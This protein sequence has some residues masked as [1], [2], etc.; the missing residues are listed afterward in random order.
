MKYIGIAAMGSRGQ[1]GLNGQIPWKCP[2]DLAHFKETTMNGCLI[3]GRKT[4]ESIGRPL[5][6]R[7]TIVISRSKGFYGKNVFTV[8]DPAQAT[9]LATFLGFKEVFVCGGG[10]VYQYFEPHYNQLIISHINYDGPADAWF[11]YKL[12]DRNDFGMYHRERHN[13][14]LLEKYVRLL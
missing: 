4:Y 10:Q 1:I 6:G 5:P 14:F 7:K 3:M 12:L 2:E 8:K 11:D 9:L 13:A